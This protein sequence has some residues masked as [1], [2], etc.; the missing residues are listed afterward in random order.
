MITIYTDGSCRANKVGGVGILWLKDGKKIQE[1]SKRYED[2]T[3]NI[4]ELMAIKIAL[5]SIKGK[6]DSLEIV[7]DSEYSIGCITKPWKPKKNIELI[8]S[9]KELLEIKQA[10]VSTPIKFTH[11]RGHQKDNSESTRFNNYV[12]MLAQ[13]ASDGQI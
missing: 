8:N 2:V 7:T 10:L 13:N 5:L 12:D 1:F 3:N 9:I 6:I 11:T 4:M